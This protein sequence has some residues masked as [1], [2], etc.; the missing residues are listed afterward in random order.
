MSSWS[1]ARR[2]KLSTPSKPIGAAVQAD[3]Q[4]SKHE[5]RPGDLPGFVHVGPK[6]PDIFPGRLQAC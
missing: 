1:V 5:T 2:L 4:T 3:V 6:E